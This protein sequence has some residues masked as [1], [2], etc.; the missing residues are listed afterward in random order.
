MLKFWFVHSSAL[1][2]RKE[3]KKNMA[4]EKKMVLNISI[5]SIC[6]SHIWYT[7]ITIP[8]AMYL[9]D[10]KLYMGEFLNT[11]VKQSYCVEF[12]TGPTYA[13]AQ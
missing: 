8:S 10:S 5:G 4:T 3:K 1:R 9:G 7:E 12:H 11:F 6:F 2:Y 13:F